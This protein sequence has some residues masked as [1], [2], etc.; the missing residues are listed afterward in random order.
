[1]NTDIL[2]SIGKTPLIRLENFEKINNIKANIYAK[3]EYNNPF[4]SIKDRAA[5]HII[6][7]AEKIGCLSANKG[8]I[9]ATSGNMGIALAGI[10]KIKGYYCTI[11]M[12]ENM[13]EQRKRHI[14]KHRAK[15]ILT[16]S[17]SGMR[18]AINKAKQISSLSDKIYYTDQF[19][20]N[21]SIEAHKLF[22]AKEIYTQTHGQVDVIIGGIGTGATV[23]GI[24]E[25]Y[26]AINKKVE[27]IGVLPSDNPH[28]IQGI[29][30][31]FI[32]PFINNGLIKN[33]IYVDDKDAFFEKEHI[34]KTENLYVG[35]SSGAVI[36]ALKK[37]M[38]NNEYRNKNIVLIFADGGE[39]YE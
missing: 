7:K 5:L 8:I 39:R 11:V 1:M 3:I 28:K 14:E 34:Y 18:G 26:K 12:P 30:A 16:S 2:K 36:T 35:I 25:F 32:P 19:N 31:G 6:Q 20:N 22:T 9:E 21:A 33:I 37:L 13:S 4:G 23:R 15:L 38:L 24:A 29:G 10:C 27:I 17:D